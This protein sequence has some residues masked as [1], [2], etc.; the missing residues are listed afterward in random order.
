MGG[1]FGWKSVLGIFAHP[2]DETLGAGGTFK[3]LAEQ[4][5]GV[6]IHVMADG[7]SRRHQDS[8]ISG[9]AMLRRACEVLGASSSVGGYDG[10]LEMSG[11]RYETKWFQEIV[12]LIGEYQP[13]AV[14]SHSASDMHDDHT[15]VHRAV[16]YAAARYRH[17][18]FLGSEVVSSTDRTWGSEFTPNLYWDISKTLATKVEAFE[19]YPCEVTEARGRT[20]EAIRALASYRGSQ[21][22]YQSAEAF[23]ILHAAYSRDAS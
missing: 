5:V 13:D 3:I 15:L 23:E 4:G 14:F 2:D 17:I 16:R 6:H 22:G 8:D 18:W 12:K 11:S 7:V 1:A 9:S 21:S 20:G 19:C 10:V